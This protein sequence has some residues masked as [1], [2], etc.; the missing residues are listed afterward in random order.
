MLRNIGWVEALYCLCVGIAAKPSG[1]PAVCDAGATPFVCFISNIDATA[2]SRPGATPGRKSPLNPRNQD[3]DT[4]YCKP[5]APNL[6]K[7]KD[8]DSPITL[9]W[10][11]L[12]A[13]CRYLGPNRGL[14]ESLKTEWPGTSTPD[15]N[16]RLKI[17]I[18]WFVRRVR[19]LQVRP[20]EPYLDLYG[21]LND[22]PH[23]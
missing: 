10:G 8:Q 11:F 6:L 22:G 21:K 23:P 17:Q 7:H 9:A 5:L 4:F 16:F 13:L 1:Q 20:F 2:N 12:A 3:P 15:L 18:S 19:S 14:V